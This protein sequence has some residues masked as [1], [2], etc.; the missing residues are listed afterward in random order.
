MIDQYN[1]MVILYSQLYVVNHRK[2][3]VT[4]ININYLNMIQTFIVVLE[5][6][7]CTLSDW[8]STCFDQVFWSHGT[9]LKVIEV[10]RVKRIY[11]S[12]DF[13]ILVWTLTG[14]FST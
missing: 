7:S 10:V 3:C 9:S 8:F 6:I 2:C 4:K 1:E 12:V 5:G 11:S 13:E 14:V